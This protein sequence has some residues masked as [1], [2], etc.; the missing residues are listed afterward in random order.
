MSKQQPSDPREKFARKYQRALALDE[1]EL[2]WCKFISTA[3]LEPFSQT[4]LRFHSA[5]KQHSPQ[6]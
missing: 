5:R 2:K 4:A 1:N 3:F 6:T